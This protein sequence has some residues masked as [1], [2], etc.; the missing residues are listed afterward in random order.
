MKF[1][2]P[3]LCLLLAKNYSLLAICCF[4]LATGCKQVELYERL[5]NIPKAEWK[6]DF[7]PSFTFNITDTV[8][9]YHV[10]ITVR[11]T[12]SYA[13]N[14]IWLQSTL[15]LPGD[16]LITQPLDLQLA[17]TDGWLGTGMDDIFEHSIKVTA[18]PKQFKRSGPV[19][20][21][22]KQTMRQDP[23]PGIMQI[24]V[25]VEKVAETRGQ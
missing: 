6:G 5:E 24:G 14:N 8:S 20:F 18:T 7:K 9:L 2:K 15:Q 17:G 21:T 4:L 13:Y 10:Y 19:T 12:N 23:L 25:K 3:T 16:S 11:H 22:L 1:A